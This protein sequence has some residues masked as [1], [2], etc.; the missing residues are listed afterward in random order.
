MS[1]RWIAD[2]LLAE[3]LSG[4]VEAW[5]ISAGA[6]VGIGE[7]N[8]IILPPADWAAEECARRALV[9]RKAGA[10]RAGKGHG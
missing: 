6:I 8:R 9:Q 1:E 2:L 10:T 5:L 7:L 3:V 4:L